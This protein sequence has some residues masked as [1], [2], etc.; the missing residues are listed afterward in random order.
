[1]ETPKRGPGRP[2]GST[3]SRRA[4][5]RGAP[6]TL[7]RI[8]RFTPI[9]Q[10]EF[11][12]KYD[13][14]ESD[15]LAE[16]E[17]IEDA[18]LEE[19][20]TIE[21]VVPVFAEP[22]VLGSEF[23]N[24]WT[25]MQ[26][27]WGWRAE[28]YPFAKLGRINLRVHDD[29]QRWRNESVEQCI[30]FLDL[31]T[32]NTHSHPFISQI[33]CVS[34]D[35]TRNFNRY[36][37]YKYL[38]ADFA[39]YS[40]KVK[41]DP[42]D[43]DT[44]PT[45]IQVMEEFV[46]LYTKNTVFL[47]YGHGDYS[48]IVGNF[49]QCKPPETNLVAYP[50]YQAVLGLFIEREYQFVNI[51][52]F[53]QHF[54]AETGLTASLG[55]R[56]DNGSASKLGKLYDTIFRSSLLMHST[57]HQ[58]VCSDDVKEVVADAINECYKPLQTTEDRDDIDAGKSNESQSLKMTFWVKNLKPLTHVANSDTLM[59]RDI[60][61]LMTMYMEI[62]AKLKR[63]DVDLFPDVATAVLLRCCFFHNQHLGWSNRMT[64]W[65]F[66][67]VVANAHHH[68]HTYNARQAI[69]E[70]KRSRLESE[71]KGNT[72]SIQ[73][74]RVVHA[75][76]GLISVSDVP[77][78]G[79]LQ[80]LVILNGKRL[81]LNHI[82]RWSATKLDVVKT[83]LIQNDAPLNGPSD[84]FPVD[85]F[86]TQTDAAE[87]AMGVRGID[88]K[89]FWFFPNATNEKFPNTV[90]LHTK[91][92]HLFKDPLHDGIVNQ[93][94]R[95]RS[96]IALLNLDTATEFQFQLKFCKECKAKQETPSGLTEREYT[97]FRSKVD[98]APVQMV[99]P[100]LAS[101]PQPSISNS[102]PELISVIREL[103]DATRSR[104][105]YTGSRGARRD[106]P[107]DISD[108]MSH[109]KIGRLAPVY[110]IGPFYSKADAQRY[111]FPDKRIEH[112]KTYN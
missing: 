72:D 69:E 91:M 84:E 11:E 102:A 27:K 16:P 14:D 47:A 54:G 100:S 9:E 8:R 7:S 48:W 101:N 55:L 66:Y 60:V 57:T 92:C 98:A 51:W 17:P 86:S 81:Y 39:R 33:C 46:E 56:A 19:L 104:G 82:E 29:P 5:G 88:T 58:L 62:R 109:L 20:E 107:D 73:T 67:H 76:S 1:M 34:L 96:T 79:M 43:L 78:T 110:S 71:R 77:K 52:G 65:L 31:E 18:D 35:G 83:Y 6:S 21:S 13:S 2:R 50:V 61:I 106:E 90:I 45:F 99:T 44:T 111:A 10:P 30:V 28:A 70:S 74:G 40:D 12:S 80:R 105:G 26:M 3:S 85:L 112:Q 108:R 68:N 87:N 63:D 38:N 24:S 41:L 15:D 4:R 36:V 95:S 22:L 75:E 93:S 53:M 64:N 25:P 37:R 103:V 23:Y 89:P 42:W 32:H 97:A 59:M 94:Y 49:E